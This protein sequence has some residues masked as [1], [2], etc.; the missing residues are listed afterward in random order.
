MELEDVLNYVDSCIFEY[1]DRHLNDIE[2]GI[3]RWTYEGLSYKDMAARMGYSQNT[4]RAVYGYQFWQ[5][6]K[7]VWPSENVTKPNF[8]RIVER[9]HQEKQDLWRDTTRQNSQLSDPKLDFSIGNTDDFDDDPTKARLLRLVNTLTSGCKAIVFTGARGIGKSYLLENLNLEL[10]GHFDEIIYHPPYEIPNWQTW[11][12]QLS[13]MGLIDFVNGS[14]QGWLPTDYQ[15]RQQVIQT[16]NQ[17]RYLLIV[18]RGER[19]IDSPEYNTFFQE[20][21]TVIEHQS[22]LLWVSA[23][24]PTE[25]DRR[26]T[27]EKLK[28]FSFD[29]AN[30]LLQ[31]EYPYLSD[32]LSQNEFHWKQL[33][34][35]CGG[36][37]ALLHKSVETLKSFYANQIQQFTAHLSSLPLSGKH[38]EHLINELSETEQTLLYLFALHPLSW[39]DAQAWSQMSTLNHAQLAQAWDMLHRRHLL[40][41]F[42]ETDGIC[43]ITPPYLGFYLLQRLREIFLQELNDETL[44]LFHTYPLSLPTASVEQQKILQN[45]LLI[46]VANTLKHQ[47]SPEDLHAK[48]GRLISQLTTLP[49]SSCSYAAGSLFNLAA[50][51]RLPL[52]DVSWANLTLWH[53]DLRVPGL[54]GLDFKGCQFR[55]AVLMTGVYESFEI[56][57][58]PNRAAMV[59]GDSQGFL[60]VYQW[61][62][63]RFIL[64]WCDDLEI[65]IQQIVITDSNTLIVVLI[66]QSIL[67]WDALTRKE[68]SYSD[69]S[70]VVAIC[71]IDLKAHLLAIGLGNR[72]IQL[73]NLILGEKISEPLCDANDIVRHLAF[74]PDGRILA[75]YDNNNSILVWHYSA[76]N[77]TYTMAEAPLPLNPYGDFL[78][79]Q[80]MGDQLSVIEA[81]SNDDSHKRRS[82]V[83]VRSF[84]VTDPTLAEDSIDFKVQELEINSSQPYQA[85]FSKNG[86]YLAVCDIDHMVWIWNDMMSLIEL[87]TLPELPDTLFIS[88][89]GQ[90]LLCQNPSNISI[91]SLKTQEILQIWETVSDLDQYQNCKFHTKQGFSDDELYTVQRLG[92]VVVE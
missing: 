79:F 78:A 6:L 38:L 84:T 42:S 71:S 56:A 58:H 19:L 2:K 55:E 74:S 91:W 34:K 27:V 92:G 89:D 13:S 11:H 85:T 57:L 76:S 25:I 5:F 33:V 16:L 72:E 68:Q 53:A 23:I 10:N 15:I 30:A 81:I 66:D 29:E 73:W 18:E 83:I 17:N 67:I 35:L 86:R 48:F 24:Q 63:N 43:Q 26:I 45:Y 82:K 40:E 87:I 37:P 52:V 54:Q 1:A 70:G 32:S 22:C 65:P 60:Q 7:Q 80:W 44:T 64:A 39:L 3:I 51:M 69:V 41:Y 28:G 50:H 12:K 61:V 36:N 31:K 88:D 75:G 14:E 47:F 62:N 8:L 90:Q 46:P 21:A 9:R 4:M 77:N 20:I 49:A 59:I